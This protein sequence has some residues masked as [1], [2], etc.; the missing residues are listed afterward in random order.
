MATWTSFPHT[1]DYAFD[2]TSVRKHWARLHA[3]D[4][5]PVPTNAKVLAAW[6]L[7]H[8]GEFRKAFD[9]GMQLGPEGTTV[10][11]KAAC[12]YANYLEPREKTKHELFLQAAERAAA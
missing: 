11:N 5:E 12:M 3:G 4:R 9:A 7:L 8:K 10:A 6:A 1:R 2:A